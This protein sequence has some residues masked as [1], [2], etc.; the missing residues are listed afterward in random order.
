M[1]ECADGRAMESFTAFV[2]SNLPQRPSF[3][4]IDENGPANVGRPIVPATISKDALVEQRRRSPQQ[5]TTPVS[6]HKSPRSL[7]TLP[8]TPPPTFL[9]AASGDDGSVDLFQSSTSAGNAAAKAA[10]ATSEVSALA[11]QAHN[12]SSS[13]QPP[14]KLEAVKARELSLQGAS[15]SSTRVA[16]NGTR[17]WDSKTSSLHQPRQPDLPTLCNGTAD[18]HLP[19]RQMVRRS[20]A[21]SPTHSSAAERRVAATVTV[22]EPHGVPS[23]GVTSTAESAVAVPEQSSTIRSSDAASPTAPGTTTTTTNSRT[24]ADL[25]ASSFNANTSAEIDA[26]A[27]AALVAD[28][29]SGD[30]PIRETFPVPRYCPDDLLR[31]EDK[32]WCPGKPLRIAYVTWNMA[33]NRPRMDEVSAY[34]VHPNAH[35]IVVGTQE[36]GP[37]MGSNKMQNRW[38]KTVRD[39]CLGGQYELVGKHHM[40]AVHMLVFARKR[41]VAKYVSRAHTSHVKTGLLNGL[42]G[43]KGGVAVGLV[44]SLTPKYVEASH[45][46]T[47]QRAVTTGLPTPRGER[48]SQSAGVV[49]LPQVLRTN[50]GT[51]SA[52][53]AENEY[54]DEVQLSPSMIAGPSPPALLSAT[55]MQHDADDDDDD[56]AAYHHRL[57]E[58]ASTGAAGDADNQNS[59]DHNHEQPQPQQSTHKHQ[60]HRSTQARLGDDDSVFSPA[61]MVSRNASFDLSCERQRRREQKGRLGHGFK[62]RGRRGS[63]KNQRAATQEPSDDELS[64]GT[65]SSDTPNYMTLLFITAHLAAHQGA[66]VNRNKD[67]RAI[68]HHLQLGRRG[69]YRKF[70]KRLLKQRRVLDGAADGYDDNDAQHWAEESSSEED[71]VPLSLPVV[72]AI[73]RCEKV[74]RDVT[75]EFDLTFFGGDLNYRINGT[76]KAIE[77]VIQHHRNI[78]SILINNDQLS[79]ERARGTVFQGYQEGNL[80]FR[81]TYKYE[82][83]PSNGGVTLDE[84]NFSRKKDR[85]PAYCDRVLFKKKLSSAARRVAIRLYTD[86]PNVRTSDHRPVVALFDVGT[87][88]YT[89]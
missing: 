8:T 63:D 19:P 40:W 33:N 1:S 20:N 67:Y 65:P 32:L 36:N 44:L 58:A 48:T 47:T 14:N 51:R 2:K 43:N 17:H 73:V 31:G 35:L 71:V 76:R 16:A 81:P 70:F 84:Y 11:P 25:L 10:D 72:S 5:K 49:T 27:H 60:P 6:S 38:A 4:Q 15:S 18:P 77:Y 54:T 87:R 39:V 30:L 13:I 24:P 12:D 66:V 55:V 61:E 80:L 86:V 41:D 88:A 52:A 45:A 7:S 69:P 28:G 59:N 79:L 85:M 9:L 82:V 21:A 46:A 3:P 29:L 64:D 57:H 42:G 78:R 34:C 23:A 22:H 53:A 75:E 56:A 74:K 83:S 50:Q 26:A 89:G 37:Y 62:R 68:V